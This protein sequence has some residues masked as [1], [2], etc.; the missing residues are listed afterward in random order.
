MLRPAI[1]PRIDAIRP[2]RAEVDL[3][4]LAHNLAVVRRESR[5]ARVFAVIKA[6]GYGHG[7]VPVAQRLAAEGV[8]GLCVALPEEGLELRAAGIRL[9]ILVLGGTY[10]RGADEVLAFGLTPVVHDLEHVAQI[11]EAAA[12]RR[13]SVHLKVDTGMSRLGVPDAALARFF[14][15]A[16]RYS[17]VVFEGFMSHLAFAEYDPED[18]ATQLRRFR[19][20]L[21][22]ARD[23]GAR[24]TVVHLANSAAL[25]R[26]PETH[27]DLVRPGL[28][29]FGASPVPGCGEDLRPVMRVRTEVVQ[30]RDIEPGDR[31]SYGGT[32]TATRRTRIAVLP[33]GYADGLSQRLANAG[34]VLIRGH[35]ARIVG[36]MC[37]DLTMVDV[38]DVEGVAVG[39]EVVILG[40]QGRESITASE[41]AAIVGTV[42][43]D[44]LTSFSR[45]VPRF[46]AA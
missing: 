41:L 2:T 35:R 46:H 38:T 4:A 18:T 34:P 31:V 20:A 44:I 23:A 12:G 42:P 5:A 43:H 3:G 24:P 40:T 1:A 26:F 8:D 17:S 15:R 9:P 11:H 36:R 33:M 21:R 19:R 32:F 27:F 16:R 25:L 14:W 13:V 30:L 7:A 22:I 6:D 28:A 37:M 29:L 45:R 39:D 10:A